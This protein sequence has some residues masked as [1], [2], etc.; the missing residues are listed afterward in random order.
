MEQFLVL[1]IFGTEGCSSAITNI[2]GS[3]CE[4]D[5]T[6]IAYDEASLMAGDF[7]SDGNH[8]EMYVYTDV[9]GYKHGY[10]AGQQMQFKKDL[11]WRKNIRRY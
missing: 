4:G 9:N 1:E 5:W 8:V 3:S 6:D 11:K 10:N 7:V 2:D